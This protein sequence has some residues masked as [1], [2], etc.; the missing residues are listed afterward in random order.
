MTQRAEPHAA[1]AIRAGLT[2]AVAAA[3]SSDRAAFDAATARLQTGDSEVL[4][5]I[6][7]LLV[8]GLLEQRHPDGLDAADLR[9]AITLTLDRAR[10]WWPDADASALVA[11]GLRSL[12][13][14]EPEAEAPPHPAEVGRHAVLL[15]AT[16]S[17]GHR[18]STLLDAALAEIARTETMELP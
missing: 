1:R 17:E 3:G 4:F 11:A 9:A 2:A 8:R 13:L 6:E 14:D 10:P 16:L 12:G 5:R 18:L 7:A 15:I